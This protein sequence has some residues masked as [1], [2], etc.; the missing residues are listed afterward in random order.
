MSQCGDLVMTKQS[1]A[2][3]IHPFPSQEI[4]MLDGLLRM[5]QG[6]PAALMPSLVILFLVGFRRTAVGVGGAVMQLCRALMI[7]VVRSIIVTSRHL[8]CSNPA[9]L[10]VGFHGQFVRPI[11]IFQCSLLVPFPSLIITFFVVLGRGAMGLRRQLMLLG[12][13]SV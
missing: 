11:C 6:L 8:E 7:F 1:D 3:F 2:V 13:F 12:G 4:G 9:R 5:L 10:V